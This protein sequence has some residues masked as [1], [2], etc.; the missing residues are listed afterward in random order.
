MENDLTMAV[1][2]ILDYLRKIPLSQSTIRYYRCCYNV[3]TTYCQSNGI[4]VF[5]SQDAKMFFDYQ[6]SRCQNRE[7]TKIYCLIMRKAAIILA[8]YLESGTIEWKR[9]NYHKNHLCSSY[10]KALKDFASSLESTL[11]SG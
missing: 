3:I 4:A 6:Q 1:D 7:I 10:E 2:R 9:R 11:A 8:E 5:S